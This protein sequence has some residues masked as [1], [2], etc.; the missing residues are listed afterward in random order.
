[1]PIGLSTPGEPITNSIRSSP[2]I[3][4]YTKVHNERNPA[5]FRIFSDNDEIVNPF[6]NVQRAFMASLLLLV[7]VATGWGQHVP[8]K[9][10]GRVQGLRDLNANCMLQDHAGYLWLGTD[11]GLYRYDG[12]RFQQFSKK[13]GLADSNITALV[14]DEEG[15]LWIGTGAGLSVLRDGHFDTLSDSHI[16]AGL[17]RNSS[18]TPWKG[19]VV[20]IS[21]QTLWFAR[22]TP[23]PAIKKENW[24][25]LT[26]FA[27]DYLS[28][29]Q[30]RS[31]FR[32]KSGTL[33]IGCDMSI[34]HLAGDHGENWIQAV[35]IPEDHWSRI[36]QTKDGG[37]W[38][39]GTKHIFYLARG[40]QKFENRTGAIGARIFR[41]EGASIVQDAAGRLLVAVKGGMVSWRN[42]SWHD[43]NT[44]DHQNR[45]KLY[46]LLLDNEGNLWLGKPGHGLLRALGYGQ[47]ESWTEEEG[48]SQELVFGVLRDQRNRLWV[49]A[50]DG[51][52]MSPPPHAR[53][54]RVAQNLPTAVRMSTLLEATDGSIWA[55]SR[56][57]VV[58]RIDPLTLQVQDIAIGTDNSIATLTEAPDGN[59]WVATGEGVVILRKS[60][61]GFSMEKMTDP[62]SPRDEVA[63]FA[64]DSNGDLFAITQNA[65]YRYSQD[66]WSSIVLPPD[67]K[68]A[69][70]DSIAI[71]QDHAVWVGGEEFAARL[72][73]HGNIAN[74]AQQFSRQELTTS[75]IDFIGTDHVG[76]I[77][78]GGNEAVAHYNGNIWRSYTTDDGLLWDDTDRHAF[79]ADQ[80]GSIW[81]GT[82]DG[83]SHF[84]QPA[85]S[86]QP[87]PLPLPIVEA[88]VGKQPVD[89]GGT[90]AFRWN[91]STLTATF[92]AL[93]YVHESSIAF[94][95]RLVGLE[96][97]WTLSRD[98]IARYVNLP[99][100]SYVLE[101][102]SAD[103]ELHRT[104]EVRS[105]P[106]VVLAPWWRRWPSEVAIIVLSTGLLLFLVRFQV[107]Y[108]LRRKLLEEQATKDGLTKLWNRNMGMELLRLELLRAQRNS[109]S[110]VIAMLDIDHFK[111]VND[112][113]GHLTGDVV[114]REIA[115]RLQ[116]MVRAHDTVARYGGEEF[117]MVLSD[118]NESSAVERIHEIQDS[119]RNTPV[120][121]G[122]KSIRITCSVG[123]LF[124][125]T[126]TI[127]AP[128]SFLYRADQLLYKAKNSGRN[129]IEFA[130]I[131]PETN[132]RNT[133]LNNIPRRS[134]T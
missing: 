7:V 48:I 68:K 27:P 18:L 88:S 134:G 26:P 57:G 84:Q 89:L 71:G 47:W 33:W 107:K 80:D 83:I 28:A 38:V 59:I 112:T 124:I 132:P 36:I 54:E 12:K 94:Q 35:G 97:T 106:F 6:P 109:H 60:E 82:S 129:R 20:F 99:A 66:R 98:G 78:I 70:L 122:H 3:L 103:E 123:V 72:E 19:G 8:L 128:E 34:C 115:F 2:S 42:G 64:H 119:M 9:V 58:F 1:M 75:L 62:A 13:D 104:S 16:A 32:D 21:R 40:S 108:L 55:L 50:Q 126:V 17:R 69:D 131:G 113:Y 74:A 96:N 101:V 127:D 125:S 15:T 49:A 23:N 30:A 85:V 79:F 95:Y 22:Y 111:Q 117:L 121:C 61:S 41:D 87:A 100:G 67:L 56:T 92:S 25:S 29:G 116:S 76:G 120:R 43:V 114:L 133:D 46:P 93:T 52:F 24:W 31:V 130:H 53:F 77:W 39:R 102:Y 73:L 37:L 51:L 81:I 110:V 11:N 90:S 63:Q 105:I 5:S 14:Q 10:Y 4:E 45:A 86:Q 91:D 118:I 65:L 44:F